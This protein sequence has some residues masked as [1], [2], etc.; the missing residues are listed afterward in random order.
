MWG[1]EWSSGALCLPFSG[2]SSR[3]VFMAIRNSANTTLL[4]FELVLIC[5]VASPFLP[6]V[7]GVW[8][9]HREALPEVINSPTPSEWVMC[10]GWQYW[11]L[12]TLLVRT[13][14]PYTD[15]LLFQAPP[16]Q[17]SCVHPD[18]Y[19][20]GPLRAPEITAAGSSFMPSLTCCIKCERT[21]GLSED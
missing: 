3:S 5:L 7:E 19:F 20:A 16:A 15:S 17:T 4:A 6:S 12:S 13:G 21:T 18:F 14:Y 2:S 9:H 11:A 10:L 8:K 1:P